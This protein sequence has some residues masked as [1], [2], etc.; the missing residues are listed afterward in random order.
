MAC[1]ISINLS[2]HVALLKHLFDVN[3]CMYMNSDERRRR[4]R[5]NV[6][7]IGEIISLSF[8]LTNRTAIEFVRSFNGMMIF[9]W[10]L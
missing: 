6:D 4:R 2:T 8:I 1:S 9:S 3:E 5:E 7:W 10:V